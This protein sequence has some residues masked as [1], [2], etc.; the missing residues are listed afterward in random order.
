MR[1]IR[2][3][4]KECDKNFVCAPEKTQVCHPRMWRRLGAMWR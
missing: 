1:K 4:M 3:K 2:K